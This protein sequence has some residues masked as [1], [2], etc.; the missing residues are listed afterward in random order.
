MLTQYLVTQKG[1]IRGG[2]S[3]KI[4]EHLSNGTLIIRSKIKSAEIEYKITDLQTCIQDGK[5]NE[6]FVNVDDEKESVIMTYEFASELEK[7]KFLEAIGLMMIEYPHST[8][9]FSYLRNERSRLFVYNVNGKREGS[10]VNHCGMLV[11]TN[12]RIVFVEYK[13]KDHTMP[14]EVI[15]M[16][17]PTIKALQ[18][19][20][21]CI[22]QYQVSKTDT[23]TIIIDTKDFRS[24]KFDFSDVN[25]TNKS[26]FKLTLKTMEQ[27]VYP[28]KLKDTFAY[29]TVSCNNNNNDDN[30]D[31]DDDDDDDIKLQTLRNNKD[32]CVKSMIY[33]YEKQ[34][35]ELKQELQRIC[36]IGNGENKVKNKFRICDINKDLSF[37]VSYPGLFIVPNEVNDELLIKSSKFR[38]KKRL[39]VIVWSN[40]YGIS[41]SRSAQPLPGV[42]VKRNK[43]D[44]EYLNLL[45]TTNSFQKRVL[46]IFDMRPKV[47]AMA[48]RIKGSGYEMNGYSNCDLRFMDIGNIHVMRNSLNMLIKDCINTPKDDNWIIRLTNSEWL[49]HLSKVLFASIEVGNSIIRD[50]HNVL[51]HC[52]DGWDRTS[53]CSALTQLILDPYYR[54]LNGFLILIQ[55]EWISFGHKFSSR[56]GNFGKTPIKNIDSREKSPIFVQFLDAVYQIM[57]QQPNIF[58]F[59]EEFLLTIYDCTINGLYGDF[60]CDNNYDRYQMHLSR[61]SYSIFSK[62]SPFHTLNKQQQQQQLNESKSVNNNNNNMSSSGYTEFRTPE[63]TP[64]PPKFNRN[65]SI[66]NTI[67]YKQLYINSNYN[68]NESNNSRVIINNI[69]YDV[70][71]LLVWTKCYGRYNKYDVDLRDLQQ[72]VSGNTNFL[73]YCFNLCLNFC[74]SL[75]PKTKEFMF[76]FTSINY[77]FIWIGIWIYFYTLYYHYNYYYYSIHDKTNPFISNQNLIS[78]LI[79]SICVSICCSIEFKRLR[80]GKILTELDS[81]HNLNNDY[82]NDDGSNND[83]FLQRFK[84]TFNLN[85]FI[86]TLITLMF[87]SSLF[88]HYISYQNIEYHLFKF[89]FFN[90]YNDF[91]NILIGIVIIIICGLIIHFGIN[92]FENDQEKKFQIKQKKLYNWT[93]KSNYYLEK[94]NSATVYLKLFPQNV[95]ENDK[96]IK[97]C[98]SLLNYFEIRKS[99][100]YLFSI[101]IIYI[102]CYVYVN[103]DSNKNNDIDDDSWYFMII[104]A[105]LYIFYSLL[106]ICMKEKSGLETNELKTI[107]MLKLN[108]KILYICCCIIISF[109]LGSLY[110]LIIIY[111]HNFYGFIPNDVNNT[112]VLILLILILSIIFFILIPFICKWILYSK[113]CKYSKY[114]D[115]NIIDNHDRESKQMIV[116]AKKMRDD[117]NFCCECV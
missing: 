88:I 85:W 57:I 80:V 23:K 87:Q 61:L 60:F 59:T 14:S 35:K 39:P 77:L 67:K 36:L 107:I 4:F 97:I 50:K 58:E 62:S 40:K 111:K 100:L 9:M 15:L 38:S 28:K 81:N 93:S 117:I 33:L 98:I 34:R 3:K 96:S 48:N 56:M 20:H 101:W 89:P 64:E 24:I 108:R 51:I 65:K 42:I 90:T 19:A 102:I 10:I 84:N 82:N 76:K 68:K 7:Y 2:S 79:I 31:D 45:T 103:N 94:Y 74:I 30:D 25:D 5:S 44:E 46:F 70:S 110:I 22:T 75:M 47:N 83:T 92:Y 1:Q 12:Y 49:S 71:S 55:K 18:V 52:S 13:G 113:Y 95:L 41:I 29:I 86:G 8:Q 53:Q 37:C 11:F 17:Y 72:S 32:K 63:S 16:K 114:K 78:M 69:K 104:I 109:G 27:C 99:L 115:E 105:M 54:T 91:Y 116:I 21:L 66:N 43:Y 112:I 6:I 26:L 73:F 106:T